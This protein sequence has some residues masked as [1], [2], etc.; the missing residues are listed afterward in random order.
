MMLD[1]AD[2]VIEPFDKSERDLV[3]GFARGY[4]IPMAIIHLGKPHIG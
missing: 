2:L 1:D 3:F 4:P